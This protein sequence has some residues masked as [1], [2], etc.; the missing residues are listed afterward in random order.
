MGYGNTENSWNSYTEIKFNDESISSGSTG[1]GDD[2]GNSCGDCTSHEYLQSIFDTEGDSPYISDDLLTFDALKSQHTTP[3]GNGWRNELKV[4]KELRVGISETYEE[5]DT[6]V[7]IN[8]SPGSKTIVAQHHASDTG[9][10]MKVYI[11]DTNESG[12]INSKAADGIFDVY[13]R[14]RKDDGSEAKHALGTMTSGESFDLRVVNNYGLVS[15]EAFGETASLN[16]KDDSAAY[17]KFGN[18]LQAQD[19]YT[20]AKVEDSNDF[21]SFYEDFG[22]TRSE[23]RMKNTKYVRND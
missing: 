1:G 10:L 16:V 11:S 13:A 17:F 9:T 14:L 8:M 3:N 6:R 19:P 4:K 18:Y 7:T 21:G 22:I 23:I 12:F 15:V 5:F 2:G 20:L